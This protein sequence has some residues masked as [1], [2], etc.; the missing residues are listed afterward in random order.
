MYLRLYFYVYVIP[1]AFKF[2]FSNYGSVECVYFIRIV[3][4]RILVDNFSIRCTCKGT[5][6][7][8][9]LCFYIYVI[10][11]AFTFYLFSNYGI[12]IV[13]KRSS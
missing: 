3:Y 12:F 11:N 6:I 8:L 1:N 4:K 5:C 10:P 9:H 13:W 7:Y 2:Y